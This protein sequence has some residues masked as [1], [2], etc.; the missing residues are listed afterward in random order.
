MDMLIYRQPQQPV[1]CSSCGKEL[2]VDLQQGAYRTEGHYTVDGK[3]YCIPCY[4]K[5]GRARR[6]Q[7]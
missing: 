3:V 2:Q 5:S 7:E 6:A 1:Q 4:G